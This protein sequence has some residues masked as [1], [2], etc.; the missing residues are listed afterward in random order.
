MS[1]TNVMATERCTGVMALF[2]KVI[3][4]TEC[5][6]ARVDL[7]YQ[8]VVSKKE[9]SGKTNTSELLDSETLLFVNSNS[10]KQFLN[11]MRSQKPP[12]KKQAKAHA[13]NLSIK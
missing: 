9:C 8:M 11:K 5:N 10:S 13:V 4:S 7:S 1:W 3:G 2:T 6:K 12:S